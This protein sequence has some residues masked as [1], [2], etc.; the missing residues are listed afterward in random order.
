MNPRVSVSATVTTR[1]IDPAGDEVLTDHR[2]FLPFGPSPATGLLSVAEGD[3][4]TRQWAS[5]FVRLATEP[6]VV[7]A[8][9]STHVS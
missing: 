9:L 6:D 7:R 8:T 4:L 5:W 3:E 1:A 2:Q